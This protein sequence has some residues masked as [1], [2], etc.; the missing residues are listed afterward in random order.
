MLYLLTFLRD[1]SFNPTPS[2]NSFQLSTFSTFGMESSVQQEN[3]AEM[4]GRAENVDHADV[5]KDPSSP[6]TSIL[7][8]GATRV[9]SHDAA[10]VDQSQILD[11]GPTTTSSSDSF[12]EPQAFRSVSLLARAGRVQPQQTHEE[13]LE[14]GSVDEVSTRVSTLALDP[15]A[16]RTCAACN[17]ER[18]P[19]EVAEALCRHCYCGDCVEQLMQIALDDFQYLPCRCCREPIPFGV[20]RVLTPAHIAEAYE[21]RLAEHERATE[22][23]CFDPKCAT[24]IPLDHVTSATARCPKCS[25]LT[26]MVCKGAG[27]G[28]DDCPE[29]PGINE[30]LVTAIDNDWQQCFACRAVVEKETG[31]N[32]MT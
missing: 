5:S 15:P 19:D 17:E 16:N 9:Q 28:A 8:A 31:C 22:T 29:D 18:K 10:S 24:L 7:E 20:L 25:A 14:S 3:L 13:I 12:A 11:A 27:H 23:H 26:C 32:H 4:P 6:D 30:I 1:S 21:A 2:T